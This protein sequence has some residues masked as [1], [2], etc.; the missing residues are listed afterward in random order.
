MTRKSGGYPNQG[1]TALRLQLPV[2]FMV[3]VWCNRKH[4]I[5]DEDRNREFSKFLLFRI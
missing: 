1:G 5:F 3:L 4:E 2:K